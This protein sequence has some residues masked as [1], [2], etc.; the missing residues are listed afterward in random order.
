MLPIEMGGLET[1]FPVFAIGIKINLQCMSF[2]QVSKETIRSVTY[3]ALVSM[4]TSHVFKF[5]D[6]PEARKY[7][8]LDS[9]KT[10][11][12]QIFFGDS[13]F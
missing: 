8:Y 13:N 11:L 9:K 6:L 1:N 7:K 12:E 4:M 5:M 10:F 2:I 3:C